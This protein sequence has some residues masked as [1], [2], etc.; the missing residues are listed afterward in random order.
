ML[1]ISVYLTLPVRECVCIYVYHIYVYIHV[2]TCMCMYQVFFNPHY[3]DLGWKDFSAHEIHKHALHLC[4]SDFK[5]ARVCVYINIIYVYININICVYHIYI[6]VYMYI[7][8]YTYIYVKFS[9]I[10]YIC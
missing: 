5:C 8:M 9:S 6:Y 1:Y 2:Y 4:V 3:T 10:I 7:Y